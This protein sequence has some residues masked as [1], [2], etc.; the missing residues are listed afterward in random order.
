MTRAGKT[1]LCID[2]H[3]SAVAGWCLYLQNAGYKVETAFGAQEGLSL[4]AT[5][6]IDL[7]L[8]D[9]AM[10]DADGGE[11]AAIMKRMKPDV[12]VIMFSGVRNIPEAARVHADLFIEKG[13]HPTAVLSAIDELLLVEQPAA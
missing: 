8:L 5:Q 4:F 12:R 3:K 11:V 7:V 6:P 10:P 9:F 2:D 13:Q 1:L